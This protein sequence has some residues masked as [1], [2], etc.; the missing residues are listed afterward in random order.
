MALIAGGEHLG[1]ALPDKVLCQIFNRLDLNSLKSASLTCRRWHNLVFFSEY[2]DRFRL[3]IDSLYRWLHFERAEW[4]ERKCQRLRHSVAH[5]E[6][7]YRHVRVIIGEDMMEG[8][9]SVWDSLVANVFT[10]VLSLELS[11]REGSVTSAV[12]A[13]IVTIPRMPKLRSLSLEDCA[14]QHFDGERFPPIVR[15]KSIEH[16]KMH[17]NYRLM[18]DMPKLL[19]FDGPLCV[20]CP[21]Y[22]SPLVLPK[23]QSLTLRENDD[24]FFGPPVMARLMHVEVMRLKY[25][26]KDLLFIGICDECSALKEL[27]LDSGLF[28]A[29]PGNIKHLSKLV[30]LRRLTLMSIETKRNVPFD[31][32]L[33]K[34]THL[35]QLNLPFTALRPSGM[36][37]L[38]KTLQ[39]LSLRIDSNNEENIIQY[40]TSNCV[41]LTK[42]RLVYGDLTRGQPSMDTL[43]ALQ[44]FTNLEV[45][46]FVK[47]NLNESFTLG[48]ELPMYRLRKLRFQNCRADWSQIGRLL[49]ICPNLKQLEFPGCNLTL[50]MQ[51]LDEHYLRVRCTE[52][53]SKKASWH[54]PEDW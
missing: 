34:L 45:L 14:D 35:K 18:V 8:F 54:E 13:V 5:S 53:K 46:V 32:D 9:Q 43:S 20:L 23:L 30:R 7:C 15:S 28:L 52:E 26:V 24:W 19:S 51:E 22:K 2:V 25:R 40:T 39:V 1:N 16:L 12:D 50:Y 33:S 37:N 3:R 21:P 11:I 47:A 38:P 31:F 44:R 17:T 36:V 6:R 27:Y 29:A 48:L 42:L 10:N 4:S 41:K 49:Q